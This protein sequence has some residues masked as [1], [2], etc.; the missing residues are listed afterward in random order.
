MVK[1][2]LKN[3]FGLGFS[4]PEISQLSGIEPPEHLTAIIPN[5]IRPQ[6]NYQTLHID[7]AFA[8]HC[9]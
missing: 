2:G 4:G 6:D 9:T 1:A 5:I 3:G 7:K 8:V